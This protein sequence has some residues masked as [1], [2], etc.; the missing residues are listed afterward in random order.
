MMPQTCSIRAIGSYSA[1]AANEKLQAL[2]NDQ[3]LAHLQ[4]EYIAEGIAWT[5]VEYRDNK[6]C[7]QII[8]RRPDGILALLDEESTFPKVLHIC[9]RGIRCNVIRLN[10]V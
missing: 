6:E 5:P 10:Y 1:C 2:F 7:L 8:E 4:Q 3:I 9:W